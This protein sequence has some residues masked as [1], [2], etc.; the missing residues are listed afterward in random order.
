MTKIEKLT[1]IEKNDKNYGKIL[2]VV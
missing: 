2:L 1:T